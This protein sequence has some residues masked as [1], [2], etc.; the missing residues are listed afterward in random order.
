MKRAIELNPNSVS[1]HRAYGN[2]LYQVG[3]SQAGME[4]YKQAV[5]IHPLSTRG[6]VSL[7]SGYYFDRRF[8]QALDALRTAVDLDP[9]FKPDFY[10]ARIYRDKGMFEE[11][12]AEFRKAD[13]LSSQAHLG[14]AYA[15]AGRG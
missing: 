12:I 2:Y 11:A 10:L 4:H 14:N 7:S 5:E 13:D 15:R 3:S 9:G 6:H 1:A 8:D